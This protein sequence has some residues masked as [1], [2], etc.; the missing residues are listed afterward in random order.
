MSTTVVED[1]A[2]WLTQ[3]WDE[4]E[5]IAQDADGEAYWLDDGDATGRMLITFNASRL[6]ARIAADRKILALHGGGVSYPEDCGICNE[7]L[8]CETVRLL[9]SPYVDRPGFRPEWA[10]A[11]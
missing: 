1:L 7:A 10:V 11:S 5:R 4:E 3:I 8:P 2:A 9:A 6:L